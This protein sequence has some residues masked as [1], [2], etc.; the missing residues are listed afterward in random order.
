MGCFLS[1]FIFAAANDF[2]PKYNTIA[3]Q[4][5]ELERSYGVYSDADAD[6]YYGIRITKLDQ[7]INAA[8]QR[9]SV[10]KQPAMYTPTEAEHVLKVIDSVLTEQHFIVCIK[11][12]ELSTA[13]T[14]TKTSLLTCAPYLPGYRISFLRSHP[15]DD[16]FPIDCDLGAILYLSIGEILQ[17]PLSLV[18][19]PNHNFVRWNFADYSYFNWDNNS[20]RVFPDD[21]FRQGRTPTSSASFDAAEDKNNHFLKNMTKEDIVAYYST[22]IAGNV[23]HHGKYELAE[24]L[25]KQ[26]IIVRPYD[27]LA[28]NNLSWMY[29]TVSQF[30]GSPYSDSAY[31]YSTRADSLLPKEIEYRDTYS[32]ACAAVGNFVK[33]IQVEKTAR[34]KSTRIDAFGK[35]KTCLDIG[36]KIW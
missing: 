3:H 33:A 15:N 22:I 31:A 21:A 34:N 9:V 35:G 28:L 6:S 10:K 29:V 1:L 23:S 19:V 16:Y 13:L 30:K 5:L 17:L 26:A 20:G 36:E 2:V 8:I 32:C 12:E 14:P 7:L 27:A 25:Y 11:I 18:E 24:S 4:L